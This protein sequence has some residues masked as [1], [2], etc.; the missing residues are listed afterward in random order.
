MQNLERSK[1]EPQHYTDSKI[2]K[3]G[4][5]KKKKQIGIRPKHQNIYY[6]SHL[7]QD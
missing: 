2:T 1:C 6:K 4:G 5:E 3:A 7:G